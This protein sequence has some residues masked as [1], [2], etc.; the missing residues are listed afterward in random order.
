M[1]GK[2]WPGVLAASSQMILRSSPTIKPEGKR[3]QGR[4]AFFKKKKSFPVT[5]Q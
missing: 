4:D 1:R 3:G 5:N 2:E